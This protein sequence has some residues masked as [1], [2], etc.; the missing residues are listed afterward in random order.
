MGIYKSFRAGLIG[1]IATIGATASSPS[2][3]DSG[4]IRFSVLKAGWFVGGSGGSGVLTFHGRRYP[5]SW[6]P[7]RRARVRRIRNPFCRHR[8]QHFLPGAS[9]GGIWGRRCGRCGWGRSG[10]DRAQKREGRRPGPEWQRGRIDSQPRPERDGNFA[11]LSSLRD[12]KRATV[13]RQPRIRGARAPRSRKLVARGYRGTTWGDHLST[14]VIGESIA[15]GW[16]G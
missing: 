10:H 5:V 13:F 6:R 7:E 11:A 4:I 2:Y 16:H 14:A 3:A 9:G 1:L 12:S 15:P 8:Q